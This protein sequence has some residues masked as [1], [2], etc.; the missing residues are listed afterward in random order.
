[1]PASEYVELRIQELAIHDYDIRSSFQSDARLDP[2]SVPILLDM[3]PRW[4][5][6]CFR[7]SERLTMPVVYRFNVG[8]ETY[9]MEVT[10]GSANPA[11]VRDMVVD[12]RRLQAQHRTLYQETSQRLQAARVELDAAV[13]SYFV[14]VE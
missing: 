10:E 13:D 11:S 4:L 9:C 1:M 12:G 2:E 6:M 8:C 5:R 7:P 14:E 3:T